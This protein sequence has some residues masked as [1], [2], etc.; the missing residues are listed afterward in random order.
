MRPNSHGFHRSGRAGR[1]DHI[2][3]SANRAAALGVGA[4]PGDRQ[5]LAGALSH[6]RSAAEN[7]LLV[8]VYLHYDRLVAFAADD[9]LPSLIVKPAVAAPVLP[10]PRAAGATI[11]DEEIARIGVHIG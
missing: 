10:T 9:F 1:P 3:P 6:I 7:S 8:F 5:V 2:E 4:D 11:L